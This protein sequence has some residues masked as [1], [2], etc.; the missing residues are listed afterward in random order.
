MTTETPNEIP[1]KLDDLPEDIRNE[2]S[3]KDFRSVDALAKSYVH[4]AKLVGVDKAQV[5]KIP[6]EGPDENV[7]KALGKPDK[8]EFPAD[9]KTQLP[10]DYK[11]E[12]AETANK[13][14]LTKT[15]WEEMLHFT[16][17]DNQKRLAQSQ[18]K[19]EQDKATAEA[20]L[21]KE[22]GNAYDQTINLAKD[23]LEVL[24]KPGLWD[25]LEAKGLTT[26]PE[27]IGALA[28]VGRLSKDE[29]PVNGTTVRK[30]ELSP[31]QAGAE[32]NAMLA[33]P[34]KMKALLNKDHPLHNDLVAER[35]RLLQIAHPENP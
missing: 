35:Y 9:L 27:L 14:H 19:A 33:N 20:A 31:A 16:D 15:Q 6:K 10:D 25:K 13:L 4:A 17:A 28:E 23:A 32:I 29:T 11:A 1:F 24:K 30:F 18:A 22:L 3:L 2:P 8:Y 12:L 5:F 26:D 21:K 34:E 7:W